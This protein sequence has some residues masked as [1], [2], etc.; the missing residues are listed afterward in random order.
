M[1]MVIEQ[2]GGTARTADNAITGLQA[3]L[4]FQ[5]DVVLLDISMPGID[6]YETCRRIR[7]EVARNMV[8]VA[9]TGWGQEHDKQRSL[10]AGFD[11]HLTKPVDFA[12]FEELLAGASTTT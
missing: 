4:E 11:A 12:A 6:G 2:L 3:I 8:I 9:L 5:P 1:A 10:E 7:E